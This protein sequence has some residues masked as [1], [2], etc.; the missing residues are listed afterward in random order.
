[1]DILQAMRRE[2][3]AMVDD[4]ATANCQDLLLVLLLVLSE[5][6]LRLSIFSSMCGT[7][8]DV[9]LIYNAKLTEDL[10]NVV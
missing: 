4:N 3:E 9:V 2:A 8:K 6:D 10:T 5:P 1:L 7:T